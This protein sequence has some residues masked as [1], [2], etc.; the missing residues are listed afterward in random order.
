MFLLDPAVESGEVWVS[1]RSSPGPGKP[2]RQ[3]TL[4]EAARHLGWSRDQPPARKAAPG[5]TLVLE[6]R[7]AGDGP[8]CGRSSSRCPGD[9]S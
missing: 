6:L 5:E 2:W 8:A 7:D 1:L 3:V 9:W 4:D